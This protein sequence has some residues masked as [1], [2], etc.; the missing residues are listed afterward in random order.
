[1][2]GQSFIL[3]ETTN[4]PALQRADPFVA[5]FMPAHNEEPFIGKNLEAIRTGLE[6]GMIHHFVLV[7]D[8]CSDKTETIAS[9]VLRV[10]FEDSLAVGVPSVYSSQFSNGAKI[11]ALRFEG[12]RGKGAAFKEAVFSLQGENYFAAENAVLVTVDADALDLR[13]NTAYQLACD[14]IEANVPMM[15]G[16]G[17]EKYSQDE[18]SDPKMAREQGSLVSADMAGFRAIMGSALKPMLEHD[19]MWVELFPAGICMEQALNLLIFPPQT[20]F[21][22]SVPAIPRSNVPLLF[23]EAGRNVDLYAQETLR[24][25]ISLLYSEC[26]PTAAKPEYLKIETTYD[27][28]F[29]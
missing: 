19:L 25:Q 20:R 7:L 17:R 13:A 29:K 14:L 18:V 22:Y 15:L 23:A 16:Q 26:N 5:V 11:T 1:M 27:R 9:R 24:Q 4:S 8:G 2:M 12:V 3:S 28:A 6:R 21:D 10:R